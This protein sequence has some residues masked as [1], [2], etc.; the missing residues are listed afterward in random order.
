MYSIVVLPSARKELKQIPE[1]M[2]KR[3]AGE[4]DKL[5]FNPFRGKKLQ[6]DLEGQ[7]AIRIWPYRVLYRIEK[8]IVTVFI[9][10]IG[11]RQGIY[12]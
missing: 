5:S 12:K 8:K 11:H 1:K 6:G 3:I 10:E 4:I 2:Q 7:Y 9:L